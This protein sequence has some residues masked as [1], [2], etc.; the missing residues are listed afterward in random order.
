MTTL[1]KLRKPQPLSL[2]KTKWLPDGYEALC[3]SVGFKPPVLVNLKFEKFMF[4]NEMSLYDVEQV[5]KY[6]RSKIGPY[7]RLEWIR[8]E[9]Y[10]E[11]IP[12]RVLRCMSKIRMEYSDAKFSISRIANDPDPFARVDIGT[13][14]YFI[15]AVWDEPGFSG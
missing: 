6:I 15:F 3:E 10:D 9:L 13:A 7:Q 1:T 11:F 8:L 4:D 5:D 14:R 12:V 2:K